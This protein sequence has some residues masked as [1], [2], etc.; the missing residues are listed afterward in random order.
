MAI[1]IN[2]INIKKKFLNALSAN[3]FKNKALNLAKEK[4]NEYK[5]EALEEYDEHG[6]TLELKD[7]ETADSNYL[8]KGNIFSF[9]GFNLGDKPAEKLREYIRQ[10]IYIQSK[11]PIISLNQFGAQYKF[12]TNIPSLKEI[13]ANDIFETPDNWSNKSWVQL[14]EEGVG[15]F[16]SYIY[17]EYFDKISRSSTGLQ[18]KKSK[19]KSGKVLGIPWVSEILNNMKNKFAI[20]K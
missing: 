11:S 4:L 18:N 8:S 16:A 15:N 9:I 20:N 19:K 10:Q 5:T 14:V 17:L 7:G 6:V 13:Y 12:T 1:I 3:K 2:Q